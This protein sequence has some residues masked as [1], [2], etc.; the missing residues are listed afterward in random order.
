MP[1]LFDR[2]APEKISF[3]GVYDNANRVAE[4][5]PTAAVE[6]PAVPKAPAKAKAKA[7]AAE[8]PVTGRKSLKLGK[9]KG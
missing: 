9:P 2:A 4:P 7:P 8:A 5:A 6:A 1:E 3:P